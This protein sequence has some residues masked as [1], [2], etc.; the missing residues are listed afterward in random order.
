MKH[1]QELQASNHYNEFF[2]IFVRAVVGS[3]EFQG[4]IVDD[5]READNL[6]TPSDEA[7]AHLVLENNYDRWLDIFI[8][9]K[10]Q[11]PVPKKKFGNPEKQFYSDVKPKYT[12]GGIKYN[13]ESILESSKS[14]GWSVEGIKRFNE[15]YQKIIDDRKEHKTWMNNF[16][17]R[18]RRRLENEKAKRKPRPVKTIP[19][20]C[21]DSF[22]AIERPPA[23]ECAFSEIE[24]DS[25]AETVS[26]KEDD[27]ENDDG[28]ASEE[29]DDSHSEN[30][31]RQ[32]RQEDYDSNS[33]NEG[34]VRRITQC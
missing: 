20:A 30:G 34:R 2:R 10:N 26:S 32:A 25:D 16:I 28:Q 1:Y 27:E 6:C 12:A 11:A 18:E 15:L 31:D 4:R 22:Q 23:P 9:N 7:F 17:R 5:R 13:D 14:K 8:Q 33:D 24:F 21:R 29:D 3:S 19:E